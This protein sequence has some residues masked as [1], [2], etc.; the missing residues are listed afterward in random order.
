MTEEIAATPGWIADRLDQVFAG[1]P[2]TGAV[3]AARAAY[4]DCLAARKA[5]AAPSDML[6]TEFASC[7]PGLHAALR[8]AGVDEARLERLEQALEAVEA[9]IAAGS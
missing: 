9:E 7:R 2:G 8:Q 6:G 5:P 3:G 4:E 1:L